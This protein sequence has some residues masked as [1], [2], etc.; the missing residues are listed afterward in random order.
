MQ[1]K[2]LIVDDEPF[3]LDILEQELADRGYIIERAR[4]GAEALQKSDSFR[5]DLVLLDYMMPGMNGLEVLTEIRKR[6][7]DVPIIMITAHGSIEVAVQA[8]KSGAYDFVLK[9]F[10]PDHIS[11]TVQKALEHGRLKREVEV[12]AE[13]MGERYRLVVGKSAKMAHAVELAKK[14]AGSRATVLLFGESGTG[15]EIF[16]RAI[17]NW[18]DR[19]GEPFIAINCVG[20][21]RELLESE[22][23]GHEK[24]AFTGAHRLK[25]GKMEL[26]HHG[27][28]LL[29]EVGDISQELQTKLL[30]FLQEREFERVGGTK[31]IPVDVRIIAATSR[32]LDGAVKDG[33]FRED[34]Y[35]R[36]NV[37]PMTLPP[38]RERREDIPALAQFFLHRFSRETKKQV[39][40]I[41]QQALAK[42][43]AY[44]WPGNVREL[45][46][47]MERAIVLGHG[48]EVA[49]HDLP[50]RVIAAEP[51]GR[52]ETKSYQVAVNA[53]R[54]ELILTALAQTGGNR[55]AAAKELG[56]HRTHLMRLLKVLRIE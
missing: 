14:A 38:L 47:V 13:E 36:L 46:N 4:D 54:R 17:H 18:S 53:Y 52:S 3:N 48:P 25:K 51:D 42:L 32:D 15:K 12:F 23:F 35:H 33:R 40:E 22:L 28:V 44:A 31:P 49:L 43:L 24:G 9:P 26:A 37:I 1:E 2:I 11:L 7:Y 20:L 34:L 27:T 10:E 8:M 6:E 41:A 55:A 21:S 39:N 56:L 30:R 5:P 45:A 19:K 29:D 16:A 50:P